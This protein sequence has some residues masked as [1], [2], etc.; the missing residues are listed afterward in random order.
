MSSRELTVK[1]D[2]VYS[3]R[4]VNLRVDEVI[5]PDGRITSR[6][7]VEHRGAVAVLAVDGDNIVFVKQYRKPIEEMLLEIPAGTLE[8]GE[9]PE[10]CARRELVEETDM[11]PISLKEI[12]RFYSSP[13]FCTEKLYVFFADRF[14][15]RHGTPDDDEFI[16]VEKIPLSRVEGMLKSGEVKDSKTIIALLY[17]ITDREMLL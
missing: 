17:F 4:I 2:T 10:D 8:S 3:G 7:I 6:E 9:S 12:V 5:L 1:S 11:Y 14:E 16:K 13:G 15:K